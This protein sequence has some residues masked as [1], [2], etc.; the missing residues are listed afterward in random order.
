MFQHTVRDDGTKNTVM[1]QKVKKTKCSF[2]G[3]FWAD[4]TAHMSFSREII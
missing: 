4:V 3:N 1:Y 2:L